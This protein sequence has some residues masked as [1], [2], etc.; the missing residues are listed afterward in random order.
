MPGT[1]RSP[2]DVGNGLAPQTGLSIG[3][4]WRGSAV[5]RSKS[6]PSSFNRSKQIECQNTQQRIPSPLEGEGG[7]GGRKKSLMC[8]NAHDPSP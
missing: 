3:T 5:Q 2:F 6:K 4:G 7:V 1:L 8:A